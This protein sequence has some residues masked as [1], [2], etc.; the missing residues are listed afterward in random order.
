MSLYEKIMQQQKD[1]EARQAEIKKANFGDALRIIS[2][3]AKPNYKNERTNESFS[4]KG[5]SYTYNPASNINKFLDQKGVSSDRNVP[6]L[7]AG[8][9]TLKDVQITK[10]LD[11]SKIKTSQDLYKSQ[12]QTELREQLRKETESKIITTPP[13]YVAINEP[14]EAR[15]SPR[16]ASPQVVIETETETENIPTVGR[17]A[18]PIFETENN[19]QPTA[20]KQEEIIEDKQSTTKIILI[21]A[22]LIAAIFLIWRM[23]K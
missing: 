9:Q 21:G 5:K 16:G 14:Q 10:P 4:I 23:K 12:K 20:V 7:R 6:V 18:M 17:T 22:G 19:I 1:R 8:A 15:A 3:R 2:E 11:L 13:P